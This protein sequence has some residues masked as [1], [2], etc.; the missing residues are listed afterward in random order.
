M[1]KRTTPY[2][3]QWA[4]LNK[5]ETRFLAARDN[6]KDTFINQKLE[7]FVPH[8]LQAT[9]DEAFAK[10]FTLIFEKGTGVIEK[11]YNKDKINKKYAENEYAY[12][13]KQSSRNLNRFSKKARKSGTGNIL[14]SGA[15]GIGMGVAGVG[16]P[17]IPVFTALLFRSVYEIALNY[18]Y[19]YGNER[20]RNF[21]LLVI[22][23]GVSYGMELI[24]INAEIDNFIK[25]GKF[26]SDI[27]I[28][29]QIKKT[30]AL[31]SRE[32][33]Y[34]KFLQGIPI[35]GAIGGFYDVVYLKNITEYADIKYKRRFLEKR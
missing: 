29:A 4:D 2:E 8:K 10:V 7:K 34:M 24:R 11:T 16:I 9:L 28:P 27:D 33:L 31:L 6:K 35:A 20:E 13:T 15:A 5:K 25:T 26:S 14:V 12:L 17:D 19:D 22:Q 23:G 18:G 32:L 30:S 3:R 21:I 1:F